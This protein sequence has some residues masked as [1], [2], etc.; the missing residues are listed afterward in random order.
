MHKNVC[1]IVLGMLSAIY[2]DFFPLRDAN[3]TTVTLNCA[4]EQFEECARRIE[5]FGFE[6][7]GFCERTYGTIQY[8]FDLN[9]SHNMSLVLYG[10]GSDGE[11][12]DRRAVII[13]GL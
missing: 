6:A 5:E 10:R 13:G 12:S 4:S 11:Y 9:S 3:H 7:V 2:P 1:M 8:S